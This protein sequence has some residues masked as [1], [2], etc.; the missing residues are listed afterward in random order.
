L[1]ISDITIFKRYLNTILSD[2]C[3]ISLYFFV[4]YVS[5][6]ECSL[7]HCKVIAGI[8]ESYYHTHAYY[9]TCYFI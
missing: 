6:V 9:C 8:N 3:P 2:A 1:N 4:D 7:L 5:E